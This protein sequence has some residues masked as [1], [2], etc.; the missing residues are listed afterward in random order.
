M[1]I[2]RRIFAGILDAAPA[3]ALRLMMVAVV[4]LGVWLVAGRPGWLS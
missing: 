2:V 1:T 3:G 4:T